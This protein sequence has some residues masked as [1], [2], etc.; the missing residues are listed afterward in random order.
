MIGQRVCLAM[1]QPP[2]GTSKLRSHVQPFEVAK[3]RKRAFRN[4]GELVVPEVSACTT[5]CMGGTHTHSQHHKVALDAL[6]DIDA[7]GRPVACMP[8]GMHDHGASGADPQGKHSG[9]GSMV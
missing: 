4:R 9:N 3:A 1:I 6:R 7:L 5:T 8:M 2:R